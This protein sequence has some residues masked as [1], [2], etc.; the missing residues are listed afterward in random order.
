MRLCARLYAPV[1]ACTR[2]L[3]AASALLG[4]LGSAAA[5]PR[6][7]LGAL[8][9][10]WFASVGFLRASGA[11]LFQPLG[12]LLRAGACL[13]SLPLAISRRCYADVPLLGALRVTLLHG[14]LGVLT[15]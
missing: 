3:Y 5:L 4:A 7:A 6:R 1:R 8:G 2:F 10:P 11:C 12:L 15:S 14:S 13:F 9:F